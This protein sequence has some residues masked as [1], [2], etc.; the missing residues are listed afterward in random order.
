MK[1]K[2]YEVIEKLKKYNQN[3]D[4][5]IVVNGF[6]KPYV[7]GFG[8]DEGCSSASCDRVAFIVDTPSEQEAE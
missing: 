4:L 7:M 3:A 2:V 6:E 1:M 8:G 5:C